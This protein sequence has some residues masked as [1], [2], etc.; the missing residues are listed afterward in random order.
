MRYGKLTD[1]ELTIYP[2]PFRVDGKLLLTNDAA[3]LR[4][5]GLL[6]IHYTE[7]PET[8]EGYRAESAWELQGDAIVQIWEQVPVEGGDGA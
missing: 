1:A 6:P 5:A 2:F 7:P 3:M 4:A 8:G